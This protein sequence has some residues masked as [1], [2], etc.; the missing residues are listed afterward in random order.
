MAAAVQAPSVHTLP[1]YKQVEETK[2][3]CER[4]PVVIDPS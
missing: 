2:H 1:T 4:A 3:D